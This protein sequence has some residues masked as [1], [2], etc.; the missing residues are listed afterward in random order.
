[1]K[2]FAVKTLS[3]APKPR[4][5]QK[6]SLTKDSRYTVC[7][8]VHVHVFMSVLLCS[9]LLVSCVGACLLVVL[10]VDGPVSPE[11]HLP[12]PNNYIGE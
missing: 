11:L 3:I 10:Y 12:A 4:N 7:M 2:I 6:F 5:S 8:Y 1:M 9:T